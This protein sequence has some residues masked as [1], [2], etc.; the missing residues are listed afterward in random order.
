MHLVGD[1]CT[2]GGGPLDAF[3]GVMLG[4]VRMRVIGQFARRHRFQGGD[5]VGLVPRSGM[6]RAG[7]SLYNVDGNTHVIN[8]THAR[9]PIA[10]VGK[11][12]WK[13]HPIGIDLASVAHHAVHQ[14][15][16]ARH[17]GGSR[18]AT[19]RKLTIRPRKANARLGKL[20]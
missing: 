19:E 11:V 14:R 3:G 13:G 4:G 5:I 20:I 16:L 9:S 2:M 17:D 6:I 8:L 12:P 7:R 10:V 18:G 1:F 15:I